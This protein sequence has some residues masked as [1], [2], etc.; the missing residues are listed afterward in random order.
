V[1]SGRFPDD[2]RAISKEK[3]AGEYGLVPMTAWQ[4]VSRWAQHLGEADYAAA[5]VKRYGGAVRQFLA[6]YEKQERR[7][8]ELADL[9]PI[10]MM[11]TPFH[12]WQPHLDHADRFFAT[13]PGSI[14]PSTSAIL[15]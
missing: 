4:T 1:K 7:P 5:T 8:I 3:Q 14:T 12:Q 10:A 2:L 15:R 9:T 11:G 6:W 13:P